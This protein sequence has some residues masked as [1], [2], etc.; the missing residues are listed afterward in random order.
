MNGLLPPPGPALAVHEAAARIRR[1]AESAQ[2]DLDT[3][4]F[5]KC[6]DPATAWRDGFLNGM[7]GACSELAGLF[8]PALA[9]EL[10]DW[11]DAVASANAR[12][13]TP[14]PQLALTVARALTHNPT[15]EGAQ[16]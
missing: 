2:A 5:W 6:Y 14:L 13:G 12:H 9:T 1:T 15:T 16:A 4:D 11:L 8:T 10:A 3:D 7:G